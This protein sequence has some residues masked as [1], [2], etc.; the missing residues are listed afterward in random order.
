VNRN[1]TFTSLKEVNVALVETP[2]SQG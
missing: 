1:R 2:M